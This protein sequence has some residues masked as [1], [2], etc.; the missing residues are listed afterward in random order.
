MQGYRHAQQAVAWNVQ[1]GG[2]PILA[3]PTP[4]ATATPVPTPLPPQPTAPGLPSVGGET[5]SP[6]VLLAIL[7]AAGLLVVGGAISIRDRARR[8]R[9]R[10]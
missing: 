8:A 10:A 4:E 1:P 6:V 5:A 7:A 3:T 2:L 9:N